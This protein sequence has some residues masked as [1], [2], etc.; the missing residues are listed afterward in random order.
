[1]IAERYIAQGKEVHLR[2]LSPECRSLL[3]KSG[4][5]CD[6]NVLEDPDYKIA[7]DDFG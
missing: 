1:V 6:V 3:K 5:V 7:V 2:H 4:N